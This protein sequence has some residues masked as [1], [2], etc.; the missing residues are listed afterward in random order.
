[1]GGGAFNWDAGQFTDDT[2]MA[3]FIAR[4]ISIGKDLGAS[5]TLDTLVS[6]WCNWA[7]TAKDVG[8]QTRSVLTSLKTLSEAEARSQAK[9]FHEDNSGR[10]GGNGGL[11]RAF[12]VALAYPQDIQGLIDATTRT[13]QL[14]HWEDDAYEAAVIWNLMIRNAYQTQKLEVDE[15]ISLLP[16]SEN[17]RDIWRGRLELA[18]KSK[19]L[20]FYKTNGWVVHA[21]MAAWSCISNTDNFV[22]A[23][24][25]AV[26][27]GGDT[28]TVACIVGALA[29][30]LYGF[31]AIP[32]SWRH[33]LKGL[34]GVNQ[35][36]LL[37]LALSSPAANY[38]G[39]DI[40]DWPFRNQMSGTHK[41]ILIQHPFDRN[42]R[43]GNLASIDKEK[44]EKIALCRVG[45]D[46]NSNTTHI[47]WLV[48]DD[49]HN[50]NLAFTIRDCVSTIQRLRQQ[51][52]TVLIFCQAGLSRTPAIAIAYATLGL[53]IEFR[54]TV[55]EL[56]KAH[57]Q[58]RPRREFLETIETL[59][60]A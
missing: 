3:I 6:D 41:P 17:K 16:T 23:V 46:Q 15:A 48:D 24:E 43:M 45:T 42:V 51:G 35:H 53:G 11:M 20:D 47:F 32:D 22:D 28:D 9:R 4:L 7:R 56:K 5:A 14:T 30:A 1:M 33:P 21:I 57:P 25:A 36:E 59:S 37:R 55:N 2:E 12:P 39:Q 18:Q 58:A 54:F 8:T 34:D 50:N 29:G 40:H 52:K 10:S 60:K 27:G 49:G 19:P 31:S 13:V 26:R 38:Q 44:A